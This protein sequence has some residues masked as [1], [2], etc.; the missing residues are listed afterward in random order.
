MTN[1]DV[2]KEGIKFDGEKTRLDLVSPDFIEATAE[3]LHWA[4]VREDPP[5]YPDHNWA[6]G[7]KY[8]RVFSALL[9]HLWKWWRGETFDEESGLNHLAHA[10]CCL[11][12]L[13]HYTRDE[14]GAYNRFDNRPFFQRYS[15]D[16]EG[17]GVEEDN[18]H[19]SR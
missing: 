5:P 3:V 19:T 6:L 18:R 15:M 9:R 14:N 7:L 11:M 4:T 10:A 1:I 2:T 16:V 8:S 17:R 13:I 12:F